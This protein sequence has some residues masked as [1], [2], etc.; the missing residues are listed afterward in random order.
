M[1]ALERTASPPKDTVA[2]AF[3]I[4]MILVAAVMF[5]VGASGFASGAAQDLLRAAGFG[6]N[7]EI[8]AEL[9]RHKADIAD[10]GASLDRMIG[11]TAAL[12]ARTQDI[13]HGDA[14][15]TERLATL[16]D[17]V[18]MLKAKFH[19]LLPDDPLESLANGGTDVL[20]LRTTLDAQA[21]R[22]RHE[23][24]ALNKRID[25]L[26]NLIAALAPPDVTASVRPPD[27]TASV[28]PPERH[29]RHGAHGIQG[30]NLSR[31]N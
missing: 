22:S 21:E 30:S 6:A 17:E 1:A 14:G 26:E 7:A 4:A 27:V 20:T 10:I 11:E 24:I 16:G 25:Y 2:F 15:Q 9:G 29:K 12:G 31:G 19:A 23:Y 18:A 5:G 8:R 13:V 28:R 3:L